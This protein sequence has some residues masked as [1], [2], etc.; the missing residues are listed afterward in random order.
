M[1]NLEEREALKS[2]IRQERIEAMRDG[3]V[4]TDEERA[5]VREEIRRHYRREQTWDKVKQSVAGWLIVAIIGGIGIVV[6]ET[7][8]HLLAAAT[9]PPTGKGGPSVGWS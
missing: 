9:L 1:F 6:F 5:W 7:A 3:F 4:L 8:R 2:V